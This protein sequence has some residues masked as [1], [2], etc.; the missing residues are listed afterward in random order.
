VEGRRRDALISVGKKRAN[1]LALYDK[2]ATAIEN[3]A[4]IID[5]RL[6][7]DEY[8]SSQVKR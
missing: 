8:Y 6:T 2:K 1:R 4:E 3:Q 7:I 5:I